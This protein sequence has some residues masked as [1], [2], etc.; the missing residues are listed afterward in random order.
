MDLPIGHK[1]SVAPIP[2]FNFEINTDGTRLGE[3]IYSQKNE[4]RENKGYKRQKYSMHMW[5]IQP[6][7]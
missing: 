7:L 6:I 2:Y 5:N 3:Y 4:Q 1:M